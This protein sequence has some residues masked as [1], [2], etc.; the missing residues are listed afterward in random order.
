MFKDVLLAKDIYFVATTTRA[1]Y[2][3]QNAEATQ[4]CGACANIRHK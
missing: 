3:N 1:T 2:T 4:H